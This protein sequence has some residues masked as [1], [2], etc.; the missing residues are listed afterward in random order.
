MTLDAASLG[1]ITLGWLVYDTEI[2]VDAEPHADAY[3]IN[4]V[5]AG[6]M[7]AYCGSHRSS[8]RRTPG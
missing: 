4:L 3:Q 1:P 5:S 2:R 6:Q 7:R 8:R